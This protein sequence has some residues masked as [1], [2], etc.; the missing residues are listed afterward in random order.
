MIRLIVGIVASIAL[1]GIAF[2]DPMIP[3]GGS[4]IV[5]VPPPAPPAID[6]FART[7]GL[8]AILVSAATLTWTR[9][10]KRRE[11]REKVEAKEPAV[12][13]TL[14]PQYSN[15]D[16]QA[17]AQTWVLSLSINVR[18]DYTVSLDQIVVSDGFELERDAGR[19]GNILKVS[20]QKVSPGQRLRLQL[21]VH[22][23]VETRKAISI[24]I[25][26]TEFCPNLKTLSKTIT[27]DL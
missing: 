15:S 7:T 5:N 8:V 22:R 23:V 3:S 16:L 27:R 10:D 24:E 21:K 19:Y 12:D 9:I 2:A 1:A 6:W 14:Q 25:D 18:G 20:D 11:R 17:R 26:M 13:L 4:A